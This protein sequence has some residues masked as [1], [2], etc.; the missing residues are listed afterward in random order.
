LS[1]DDQRARRERTVNVSPGQP[2]RKDLW[3]G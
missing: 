1:P 2:V 3:N